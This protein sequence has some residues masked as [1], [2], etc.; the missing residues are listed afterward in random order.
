MGHD[1]SASVFS[2]VARSQWRPS[3]TLEHSGQ[4]AYC[5]DWHQQPANL[6]PD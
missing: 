2:H 4:A 6:I 5:T 1:V 3:H